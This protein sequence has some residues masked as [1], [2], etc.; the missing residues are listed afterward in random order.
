MLFIV[1]FFAMEMVQI[2][3]GAILTVRQT[4]YAAAI[5]Y[6]APAEE[7]FYRFFLLSIFIVISNK[8]YYSL[9]RK[10]RKKLFY[11]KTGLKDKPISLLIGGIGIVIS[12][13]L[14]MLLHGNYYDIPEAMLAIFL[15]GIVL[16]II[17]LLSENLVSVI[18]IHFAINIS[19]V[20]ITYPAPLT[21][22]IIF[23]IFLP[24]L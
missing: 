16:G 21:I 3:A 23:S 18:L 6:A 12:S 17:Y 7:C 1:G 5:V 19:V 10:S 9:S 11:V 2:T 20:L 24:I 13:T 4:H 22:E 15:S 14:W 8:L